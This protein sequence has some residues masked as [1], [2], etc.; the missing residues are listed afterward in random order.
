MKAGQ[1]RK[2]IDIE[3]QALT[4]DGGGG[5]TESWS[6][7]ASGIYADV[8][9]LSGRE[10]FQAQQ[11]NDELSHRVTI[12][13]YPGVTSKMRVKYGARVL[14]IESI[15]DLEEKHRQVQ[16]MCREVIA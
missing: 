13:Y 1:L 9:P 3:Q 12:R 2:R 16:L 4:A 10:L 15:I 8:E 7:L 11:V 5:D 14:L 6:A